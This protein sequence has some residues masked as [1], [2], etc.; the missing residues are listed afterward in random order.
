MSAKKINR[1]ACFK[2]RDAW[3][4]VWGSFLTL[5][6]NSMK[7]HGFFVREKFDFFNRENVESKISA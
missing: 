6:K 4:Q 7:F 2:I 3:L 5:L 1:K